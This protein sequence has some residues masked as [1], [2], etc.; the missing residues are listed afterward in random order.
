[1]IPLLDCGAP[2]PHDDRDFSAR[3]SGMKFRFAFG[4]LFPAMPA[5]RDLH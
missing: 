3:D 4:V 5:A 1:M 2:A